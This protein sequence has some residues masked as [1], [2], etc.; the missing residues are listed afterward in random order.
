MQS[1]TKIFSQLVRDYMR[2][3]SVVLP[4]ETTVA[5]LIAEMVRRKR[6]SALVTD[7]EGRL[8]GI[9]TERDITRRIA[10]RCSGDEPATAVMTAPVESIGRD[11]YLYVAIARMQRF[12]WRHMPV[13][14][15]EGRP[16]GTIDLYAALAVAAEPLLRQIDR[17]VHENS[18]DG[19]RE[20]KAAQVEVADDLSRDRVPA[21]EIQ[22]VLS[23]IN[24]GIH[25]RV[26]RR[27]LAAMR[28]TGWGEPP[29]PFA[30]LIMGSGGRGENFL[31]PDQDNGFILEDIPIPSMTG[32]TASSLSWPS[33]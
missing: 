13:T 8:A 11:D 5:E 24:C 27:S 3:A 2:R 32:S 16:V 22:A 15:P 26:I 19:L 25:R 23:D 28:D 1:Q 14:D 29:V 7:A 18:L 4:S 33:A 30:L 20:V 10:L 17:I 9:I 6:T 21:P 12:G 31:Y